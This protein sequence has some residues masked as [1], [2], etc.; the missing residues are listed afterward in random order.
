M[1]I[2]TIIIIIVIIN[3]NSSSSSSSSS[4]SV[5]VDNFSPLHTTPVLVCTS[6]RQNNK[7]KLR[8]MYQSI[9]FFFFEHEQI[10]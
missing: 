5:A 8:E 2:I 7:N 10:L 9:D 1:I 3:N 4:A 6:K